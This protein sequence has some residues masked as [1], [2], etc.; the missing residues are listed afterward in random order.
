MCIYREHDGLGLLSF[1]LKNKTLLSKW[2]WRY[3]G[4]KGCLWREIMDGKV[5]IDLLVLL[6][7]LVVNR[8]CSTLWSDIISLFSLLTNFLYN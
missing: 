7:N 1:E 3:G 4:E 8:S 5:G 6:S 2:L